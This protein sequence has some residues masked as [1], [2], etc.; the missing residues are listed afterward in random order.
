[1]VCTQESKNNNA[2]KS[3]TGLCCHQHI[4]EGLFYNLFARYMSR[5]ASHSTKNPTFE[6]G[7]WV[8]FEVS[9]YD[10]IGDLSATG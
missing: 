3:T 7:V 6:S 2:D 8:Y 5:R 1:M 4:D 9:I 10:S